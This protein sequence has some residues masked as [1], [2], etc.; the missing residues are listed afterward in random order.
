VN[1]IPVIAIDGPAASGKG[2]VAK[3]LANALGFHYLE[4]GALYRL[5]AL[6]AQRESIDPNDASALAQVASALEIRFVDDQIFLSG[7]EVAEQLRVESIG[8]LASQIA[9]HPALRRALLARQRAFRTA[10]GLSCDGRDMGTVVFPDAALKVFYT[11][12]VEVRA[13]RRLKQLKQKGLDANLADLSRDLAER[14]ARDAARAT[15]PL[16]AAADAL[17]L[18]ASDLRVDQALDVLLRWARERQIGVT[19]TGPARGN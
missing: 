6:V 4:S 3:G 5:V 18:D 2:T 8:N 10:P 14:D 11:A 17:I 15:A 13:E 7:Q 16:A 12:R 19:T 9:A 1:K